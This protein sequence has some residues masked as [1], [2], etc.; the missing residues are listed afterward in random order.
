MKRGVTLFF[1]FYCSLSFSQK[2]YV[3]IIQTG[4]G[5]PVAGCTL[6]VL[7]TDVATVSSAAGLFELP[8]LPTG[9]YLL[10]ASSIGMATTNI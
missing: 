5:Q 7:N 2:Q 4:S 10:E 3:G 9:E 6:R 8:S 1:L